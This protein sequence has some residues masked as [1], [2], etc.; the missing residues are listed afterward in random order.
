MTFQQYLIKHLE[1]GITDFFIVAKNI[2]GTSFYIS[3]EDKWKPVDFIVT[4]DTISELA[5]Q[6]RPKE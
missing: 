5:T 2:G 6:P 1:Q 4:G 3:P